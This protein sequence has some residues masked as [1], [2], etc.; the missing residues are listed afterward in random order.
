[1]NVVYRVH[2]IDDATNVPLA[3]GPDTIDENAWPDEQQ[4]QDH[5]DHLA[6]SLS[7]D[8]TYFTVVPYDADR[9]VPLEKIEPSEADLAGEDAR[10]LFNND[11]A[12]R[13][14]FTAMTAARHLHE[15]GAHHLRRTVELHGVAVEGTGMHRPAHKHTVEALF[16]A[17]EVMG[18]KPVSQADLYQGLL[19]TIIPWMQER[20]DADQKEEVAEEHRL[21]QEREKLRRAVNV[22]TGLRFGEAD[23]S[24]ARG[25]ALLVVGEEPAVRLTL[26]YITD[27]VLGVQDAGL[28]VEDN[29]FAI[30]RLDDGDTMVKM[31][32]RLF[33][34]PAAA[35]HRSARNSKSWDKL[36]TNWVKAQLTRQI[37]LLVIDN[38]R[39]A[40]DEPT[41]AAVG[42][43][44]PFSVPA[45]D[46][47]KRLCTWCNRFSLAL[48]AGA[49]Y[50]SDHCPSPSTMLDAV[51]T[52]A[53]DNSHLC[54]AKFFAGYVRLYRPGSGIEPAYTFE[55]MPEAVKAA[56][57]QQLVLP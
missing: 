44:A 9:N 43:V 38:L 10:A 25:E 15:M 47:L 57:P 27:R 51:W 37:D 20:I 26:N 30:A 22:P 19:G 13:T 40:V 7:I 11:P 52:K 31:N 17:A 29:A 32:P 56:T 49:V 14:A 50:S 53:R 41:F 24:L 35:W 42:S 46:A 28:Q 2:L 3:F 6:G 5:L 54:F 16:Q 55:V 45:G 12:V 36:V 39:H 1:M 8:R 34:V 48:V 4:A 33:H 18:S 21:Q 23:L